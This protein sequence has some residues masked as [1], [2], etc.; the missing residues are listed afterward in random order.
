MEIEDICIYRQ[1]TILGASGIVI[2]A[3]KVRMIVC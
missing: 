2:L 3:L 1:I